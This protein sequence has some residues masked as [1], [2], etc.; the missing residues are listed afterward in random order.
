MRCEVD[1]DDERR[2]GVSS[3]NEQGGSAVHGRMRF[4]ACGSDWGVSVRGSMYM[5]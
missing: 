1:H 2:C 3:A 4:T 5:V